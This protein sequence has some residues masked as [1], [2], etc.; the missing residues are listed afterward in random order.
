MHLQGIKIK[1]SHVDTKTGNVWQCSDRFHA[2]VVHL[3]C[4][5]LLRDFEILAI[6]SE[7]FAAGGKNDIDKSKKADAGRVL[8]ISLVFA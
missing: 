3:Y 6:F 8:I 1:L 2:P 4:F 7:R 5:M